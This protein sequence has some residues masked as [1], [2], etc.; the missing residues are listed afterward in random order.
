[1]RRLSRPMWMAAWAGL[2][3]TPVGSSAQSVDLGAPIATQQEAFGA[4]GGVRELSNGS[5]LVADP[6]TNALFR[7]DANLGSSETL[8]SEGQGPGEYEQP[9]SVWPM[10]GDRS[11]LVD[12]GNARLSLV[13]ADGSIGDGSPI[14]VPTVGAGPMAML[15]AI[16]SGSDGAGRVYFN[17]RPL[18]PDGP[19]DSVELYRL[20]PRGGEPEAVAML[21]A[22]E[23]KTESVGGGMRMSQVPLSPEDFWGVAPDGGV[24]IARSGDASVEYIAPGG[25]STRGSSLAFDRVRIGL[26]EKQEWVEGRARNG[27]IMVDIAMGGDGGR[28][29]SMSRASG[30]RREIESYDWPDEMPPFAEGRILV[31]SDGHAWIRRSMKAG[32]PVT[33]DLF[34][35]T[36]SRVRTVQI[37]QDRL[38]A[39]FGDG[40]VYVSRFDEFDQQYLEKYALPR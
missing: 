34:D 12:L 8:G 33:Y 35:T 38:L 17:G 4:I 3:A 30:Q 18:G 10:E 28:R 19:R 26:A 7:L 21:K 23:I 9:D 25:R 24:F 6:L 11:W 14:V 2:A 22:E 20:D 27:G 36:G 29:T 5:V 16:P 1:M 15:L 32:E 40:T 39:G 31:D 37:S 13:E